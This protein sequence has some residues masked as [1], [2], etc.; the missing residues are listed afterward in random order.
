MQYVINAVESLVEDFTLTAAKSN[1]DWHKLAPFS[2]TTDKLFDGL[3]VRLTYTFNAMG[4]MADIFAS[5]SALTEK[6]MPTESCPSGIFCL[7]LQGLT[8]NGGGVS[9]NPQGKGYL[10]F[11]CNNGDQ[12][13]DK[14]RVAYYC[15]KVFLPFADNLRRE[16]P[17]LKPEDSIPNLDSF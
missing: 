11:I 13:T 3:R 4:Q 12:E 9:A 2:H 6:E 7:E 5:V 16:H 10:V 1:K 14:K 8:V 17:K 15:D